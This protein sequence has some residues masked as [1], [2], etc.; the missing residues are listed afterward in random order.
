VA[1]TGAGVSTASGIPDYTSGEWLEFS[2]VVEDYS[3]GRFMK[4]Q[5]CREK[6]WKACLKFQGVAQSA[7]PNPAHLGLAA[8]ERRGWLSA[9]I[10][11]NVDRLHH[12]AG[13]GRVIEL[14]GR[15]DRIHCLG[16]GHPE[17]WK[18]DGLPE[19]G[20]PRCEKCG[21]LLKP[22]V[23]AMGEPIPVSAWAE[24]EQEVA[25]CGL[26]AVIGTQLLVSSAAALVS[27]ARK[28]GARVLF[29][30]TDPGPARE[31]GMAEELFLA[32][33]AEEAIP[34]LSF[35]LNGGRSNLIGDGPA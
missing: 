1:L 24:A 20:D 22:A 17:P 23:I 35:L 11:Q 34:A 26:I 18:S 16:C 27:A 12:L 7:R 5:K 14:H 2:D 4:S 8:L 10:T 30:N 33:R 28:N 3:F 32:C 19:A 6:Y 21:G 15:I 31:T 9:V 29:I 13:S 25:R